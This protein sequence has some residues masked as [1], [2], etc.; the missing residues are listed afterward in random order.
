VALGPVAAGVSALLAQRQPDELGTGGDAELR[1]DLVQVVVDRARA[2][3]QH[4]GDLAVRGA[5]A[6]E[7]GDLELLRGE[8]GERAG[9]PCPRGLAG[10]AQ[11]GP[12][13]LG[14]GVGTEAV[15]GLVRRPQV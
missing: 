3:E 10:G 13:E 6:D 7:T 12:G 2:Q 5:A 15:E 1:E 14:P 9:V 11:L 4:R 8:P